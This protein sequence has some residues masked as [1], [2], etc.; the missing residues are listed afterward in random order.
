MIWSVMSAPAGLEKWDIRDFSFSTI[1]IHDYIR[2]W[3][4]HAGM[5]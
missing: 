4:A 2:Q 3:M 1:P 5:I